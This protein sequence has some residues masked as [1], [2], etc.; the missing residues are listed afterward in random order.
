MDAKEYSEH[1]RFLFEE[2]SLLDTFYILE[3]YIYQL[4]PR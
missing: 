3:L 4:T 1:A 2:K